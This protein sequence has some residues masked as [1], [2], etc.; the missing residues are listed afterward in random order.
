MD[1]AV[2]GVVMC[3]VLSV[4]ASS[5]VLLHTIAALQDLNRLLVC[6]LFFDKTKP[7]VEFF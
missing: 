1:V 5:R 6:A 4:E 3:S 7:I 2:A